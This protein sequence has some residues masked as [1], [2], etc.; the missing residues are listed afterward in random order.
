M[1]MENIKDRAEQVLNMIIPKNVKS[2]I[3][4]KLKKMPKVIK[5][6]KRSMSKKMKIKANRRIN[7][8]N[9]DM[10]EMM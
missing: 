1:D 3:E 5:G 6:L 8:D 4:R 7:P 2:M 9:S 10:N